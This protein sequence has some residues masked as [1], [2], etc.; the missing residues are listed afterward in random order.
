MDRRAAPDPRR[1]GPCVARGVGDWLVGE[2]LEHL[3][4][5][6]AR[7]RRLEIEGAGHDAPALIAAAQR[8]H[9]ELALLPPAR[10]TGYLAG[11]DR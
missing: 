5:L 2:L 7:L 11:L 1:W 10:R 8:R 6:P 4:A 9:L 3:G